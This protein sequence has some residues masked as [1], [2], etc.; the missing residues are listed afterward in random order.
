VR[1]ARVQA[2][3]AQWMQLLNSLDGGDPALREA[4]FRM[5][6]ENAEKVERTG[7]PAADMIEYI[8]RASQARDR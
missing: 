1:C 4:N 5:R 3:A 7:G 6:A 8:R 2:L